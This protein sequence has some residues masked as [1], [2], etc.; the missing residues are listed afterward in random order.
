MAVTWPPAQLRLRIDIEHNPVSQEMLFDQQGRLNLR[1]EGGQVSP[2]FMIV[3][4]SGDCWFSTEPF[5]TAQF[6]AAELPVDPR[7]AG[8]RGARSR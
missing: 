6:L 2:Q 4:V 3:A 1:V 8:G 5:V 7:S